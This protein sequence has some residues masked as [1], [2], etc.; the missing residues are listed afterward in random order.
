MDGKTAREPDVAHGRCKC[1]KTKNR[2]GRRPPEAAVRRAKAAKWRKRGSM[3]NECNCGPAHLRRARSSIRMIDVLVGSKDS[4]DQTGMRES[5]RKLGTKD[6]GIQ[7]N[8]THRKCDAL[9]C[10]GLAFGGYAKPVLEQNLRSIRKLTAEQTETVRGLREWAVCA[11]ANKSHPLG[12]GLV[13][14]D[15]RFSGFKNL[16]EINARNATEFTLTK[17]RRFVLVHFTEKK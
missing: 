7:R 2:I 5:S 10:A 16:R 4:C 11:P 17:R 14:A 8:S 9:Q 12:R 15:E 13:A 6:H 1:K 3:L